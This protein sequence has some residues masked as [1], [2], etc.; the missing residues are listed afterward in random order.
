ML[1]LPVANTNAHAPGRAR[2]HTHT[3]TH[4]H[5][6]GQITHAKEDEDVPSRGNG[7]LQLGFF[8]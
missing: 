7:L 5:M 3:H 8:S 2:A 6:S 4:T 1:F